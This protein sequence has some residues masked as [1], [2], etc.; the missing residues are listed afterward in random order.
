[1][2]PTVRSPRRALLLALVLPLVCLASGPA[3]AGD[4]D[5]DGVSNKE[6]RCPDE[7]EDLDGYRDGDGCRDPAVRVR[8]SVLGPD[9][10]RIPDATSALEGEG[11]RGAGEGTWQLDAHP[12]AYT[13]TATAPGHR[14]AELRVVVPEGG[15]HEV[16]ATLEALLGR[17]RVRV[18]DAAGR[19]LSGATVAVGRGGPRPVSGSLTE[20]L[21]PGEH[22]LSVRAPGYANASQAVRVVADSEQELVVSLEK[23]VLDGDGDGITD[24]RD[25]C[26]EVPEDVDGFD[27]ADGCPD[28]TVR[29][30]VE[31]VDRLG[32]PVAGAQARV[33]GAGGDG[34]G[35]QRFTLDLHPGSYEAFATA[36]AFEPLEQELV[37]PEGRSTWEARLELERVWT[38]LILY[39]MDDEGE[40]IDEF[41]WSL[42]HGERTP[43]DG[44]GLYAGKMDPGAHTLT[45]YAEGH[46]PA[47]AR[48][49]LDPGTFAETSI[50]LYRTKIRV[51]ADKIEIADKVYF[52]T[53]KASI[54][55]ES[56]PL[57]QQVA[58]VLRARTDM[59]R[60]RIEGHTDSRGSA[61]MNLQLSDDR[62]ASVRAWLVEAGIAPERLVSVG[63]GEDQP[64]DPRE[65]EE[66]W[67]RNRRVEF[68]IEQWGE[69]KVEK[70]I[71][72]REAEIE[73]KTTA[74]RPPL[75]EGFGVLDGSAPPGHEPDW[76]VQGPDPV[77]D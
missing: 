70:E 19:P 32:R 22:V 75:W 38:T 72:P 52:D 74:S 53:A 62:A 43:G 45:I 13:L 20:E 41:W 12:G 27:D 65:T 56:F 6:D 1:M 34:K 16:T 35:G 31:V 55:P 9:G 63:F 73:V 67:E 37:V 25:G 49:L 18:V 33:M 8:V 76:D 54:K 40:P 47:R 26:P 60:V 57:L 46:A 7:A 14:S 77:R 3:L 42:D 61:A 66:A 58:D 24:E 51:T 59:E 28:P 23:L 64:V 68:V 36:P 30:T 39:V 71:E 44:G 29:T 5:G 69:L 11:G 4:R 50:T 15:Q 17:V 21:A 48:V 10:R 2:S